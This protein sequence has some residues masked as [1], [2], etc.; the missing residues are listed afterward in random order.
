M[1]SLNIVHTRSYST[2]RKVTQNLTT[3]RHPQIQQNSRITN[4]FKTIAQKRNSKPIPSMKI[5]ISSIA[6]INRKVA[7]RNSSSHANKSFAN[8]CNT[9]RTSNLSTERKS[10]VSAKPTS[11]NQQK[12]L[13]KTKNSSNVLPFEIMRKL[14]NYETEISGLKQE[15]KK[16]MSK[17]KEKD[18]ENKK[19]KN[20]IKEMQNK[21]LKFQ[22]LFNTILNNME[23]FVVPSK[24]TIK[25]LLEQ[26]LSSQN[27]STNSLSSG[28]SLITIDDKN[29]KT[30][31]LQ[32]SFLLE[33]SPPGRN[34]PIAATCLNSVI[35]K[36]KINLF[37]S[38][39]LCNTESARKLCRN[40]SEN[41]SNANEMSKIMKELEE[42]GKDV[43]RHKEFIRKL[44][45]AIQTLLQENNIQ[46]TLACHNSFMSIG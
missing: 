35:K 34:L 33:N 7:G 43:E 21:I 23:N 6:N 18:I 4:T 36:Q 20:I 39:N 8:N 31:I 37:D 1:K 24:I 28:S 12:E 16:I 27:N 45:N 10:L 2:L 3:S 9:T 22:A 19:Y 41:L 5:D 32:E 17:L 11:R 13:S 15:N 25:S 40:R 26:D 30:K 46:K 42:K 38:P 14:L 29:S 44:K